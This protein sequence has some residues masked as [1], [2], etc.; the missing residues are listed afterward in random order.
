MWDDGGERGLVRPHAAEPLILR[1]AEVRTLQRSQVGGK[2]AALGELLNAGLPVPAGFCITTA[3]FRRLLRAADA[4]PA[5]AALDAAP[6]GAELAHLGAAVRSRLAAAPIPVDLEQAIVSAWRDLLRGVACAVRSSAT[7]EDRRDASFA[8][9]LDTVLNVRAA[10]ALLRA[11]RQCWCSAFSDRALAYRARRGLGGTAVHMAVI[12]QELVRAEAAGVLFT[13]NPL[14]GREDEILIEGSYGLGEAVVSGRVSPDRLVVQKETGRIA[15]R[16]V[17]NKTLAVVPRGERGVI[18]LAIAPHAARAAALSDGAAQ[19]L[20]L[21]GSAAERLLGAPQDV[22]WAVSGGEAFV[23]QSRP[24]TGALLR[25]WSDDGQVWTNMNTG[26]VLPDVISPLTWSFLERSVIRCLE[27]LLARLGVEYSDSPL[28]GRI[29]GRVYFNL[30]TIAAIGKVLPIGGSADITALFGGWQPESEV[31]RCLA[32]AE[33][34]LPRVRLARRTFVRRLPAMVL[35]ALRHHATARAERCRA[36]FGRRLEERRRLDL[37]ALSE[38]SLIEEIQRCVELFREG[39]TTLGSYAVVGVSYFSHLQA[40]CER[41]LP[42][43]PNAA[44]QLL[45][46]IGGMASAEAGLEMWRLAAHAHAHTSVARV[47]L[48]NDGF[49]LTRAVLG[50][51]DGGADFLARWDEFMARHGHHARGEIELMNRRW[52]DDPDYVLAQVRSYL[53][54]MGEKDP[55]ATHRAQAEERA[56]RTAALRQRLGNPIKRMLLDFLLRR[57]RLG[58]VYRENVKSEGVRLMAF[59]RQVAVALGRRLAARGVIEQATDVFLLPLDELARVQGD[60]DVTDVRALVRRRRAEFEHDVSITPPAVIV[61]RLDAG[62]V[63]SEVVDA[64]TDRLSGLGVSPG[65]VTGPARV[66]LHS[67]AHER[68]RPGEILVAPFTDPGWT[69]YFQLAAGLVTDLGGLLSHGSI[70]AREYGLPAVVNVGR[71]TRII[72]TG[73]L[74][75]LDGTHGEVRI[76]RRVK[77]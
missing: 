71:A 18:Q 33:Q 34:N 55:V 29:G 35:W 25:P 49:T 26:E 28:V 6:P 22:E 21:L 38:S 68:M 61:R 19:R 11:V 47:L 5:V 43:E 12:V 50:G 17:S 77:T 27:D 75:Q 40:A 8:G 63:A 45:T 51:V 32:I 7:A 69:P 2:A 65:V 53:A 54:H 56:Q 59:V 20:A 44:N 74:L 60:P 37:E 3:A 57:A 23:L 48:A 39:M 30:N 36:A 42:G 64:G 62:D 4:L 15:Q 14:S 13:I 41:W 1:L 31:R 52:S 70:V 66:I 76:L 72:H 10:D 58:V 67:D 24:I 46:G 9:Q 73:D 16:T